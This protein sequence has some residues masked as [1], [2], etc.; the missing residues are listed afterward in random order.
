MHS[1]G[2]IDN[3]R[4]IVTTNDIWYISETKEKNKRKPFEVITTNVFWRQTY[5]EKP[6]LLLSS[7]RSILKEIESLNRKQIEELFLHFADKTILS[8][9]K[10]TKIDL[11]KL[12]GLLFWVVS[13]YS[14]FGRP[15]VDIVFDPETEV[16]Q[17]LTIVI[18][19]CDWE[20]WKMLTKE[21]KKE[22]KKSGLE[23]MVS[24]VAIVCLKGLL[25]ENP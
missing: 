19:D 12:V 16:Y 4:M 3:N 8:R 21:I 18:P 9:L 6:T 22:M 10:E 5:I 1:V 20:A 13:K 15:K 17:F 2:L 14:E 11:R 25:E 7:L 23:D 24:K